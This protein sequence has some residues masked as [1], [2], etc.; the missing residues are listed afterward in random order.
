MDY[1]DVKTTGSSYMDICNSFTPWIDSGY[2]NS[3]IY[4]SFAESLDGT[5]LEMGLITASNLRPA[6]GE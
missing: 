5:P 3:G 1:T 2:G 6:R 4:K